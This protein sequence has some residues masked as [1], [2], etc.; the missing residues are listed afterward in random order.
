MSIAQFWVTRT[1]LLIQDLGRDLT[2]FR[3]EPTLM[4]SVGSVTILLKR[5]WNLF[6][7]GVAHGESPWAGAG[8]DMLCFCLCSVLKCLLRK[9]D[10]KS[11]TTKFIL[12]SEEVST[13]YPEKTVGRS[14]VCFPTVK[15]VYEC[16]KEERRASYKVVRT[17]VL[18]A[19]RQKT[20]SESRYCFQT[21]LECF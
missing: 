19:E 2:S 15:G 6:Y 4:H 21:Q 8:F 12:N 18:V 10:I 1:P 20:F 7:S 17:L 16:K 14:S 5:G 3:P 13:F 9:F 11:L